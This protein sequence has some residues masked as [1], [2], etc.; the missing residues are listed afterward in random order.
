MNPAVME[1]YRN[2]LTTGP[3]T[4]GGQGNRAIRF[5]EIGGD[6]Y[7]IIGGDSADDSVGYASYK[8]NSASAIPTN[9]WTHIAVTWD[10]SANSLKGYRN[11]EEVF[12]VAHSQ[13][14]SQFNNVTLGVGWGTSRYY[15][16]QLDDVRFWSTRR[17]AI[18]IQSAFQAKLTGTEPGLT[19]LYQLDSGVGTVAVNAVAGGVNGVLG[20][21][22]SSAIPTWVARDYSSNTTFKIEL[23]GANNELVLT[24][25]EA[26]PD[27]GQYAWTVP[28]SVPPSSGYRIRVTRNDGSNIS[29]T[30]D[31][32]FEIRAAINTYYVND[33]HSRR[34][35]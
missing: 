9:T 26:A 32:V 4:I 23:L 12:S 1:S 11:G 10:S 20:G 25:A 30:S 15:R 3:Y 16:G 8:L 2:V 14:P 31:G 27:T 22:N 7:V 34:V 35:I 19:A 33:A 17:S 24:I 6:L 5:E 18:Q 13:W 28:S 29:D 21:G